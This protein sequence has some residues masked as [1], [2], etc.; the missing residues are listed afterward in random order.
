MFGAVV[1]YVSDKQMPREFAN[2]LTPTPFLATAAFAAGCLA[3]A[4]WLFHRKEF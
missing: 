1:S 2:A 3:L 4:S